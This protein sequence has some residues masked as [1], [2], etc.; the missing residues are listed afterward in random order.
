[1]PGVKWP[2]VPESCTGTLNGK[3]LWSSRGLVWV[4]RALL[5]FA[6]NSNV[7]PT[8]MDKI[9]SQV[10]PNKATWLKEASGY[11]KTCNITLTDL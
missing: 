10:Q 11:T 5:L 1:M 8:G 2:L 4:G 7:L 9:I 3:H 6:G